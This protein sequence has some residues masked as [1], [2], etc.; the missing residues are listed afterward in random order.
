MKIDFPRLPITS[1]KKLFRKLA[2]KGKE[3]VELHLLRS[4]KVDDFITTYPEAGDNK[5]ERV[6]FV[7]GQETND[8]RGGKKL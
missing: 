2:E 4:S 1:D 8:K 7:V 5:V 6:A 3:L